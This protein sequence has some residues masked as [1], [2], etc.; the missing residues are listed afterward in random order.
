[1]K[2]R[3]SLLK[4]FFLII[5]AIALLGSVRAGYCQSGRQTPFDRND[6][7]GD[8]LLSQDEFK[9][10]KPAFERID[11][12]NDGYISKSELGEFRNEKQGHGGNLKNGKEPKQSI[13]APDAST[14][15]EKFRYIDTHQHLAGWAG[16]RGSMSDGYEQAAQVALSTMN[17]LGIAKMILMP[18]PQTVNQE[19]HHDIDDYLDIIKK[20][21]QRFAMLAGGGTLNVM[22][23][24]SVS[25]GEVSNKLRKKFEN[26]A[27]ELLAKGALGFGEMTAEHLSMNRTHPYIAVPPDHPLFLLLADIA[28]RHDVP[29]DLHME[30]I[31]EDMPLPGR[32]RQMPNNPDRLR[33]NIAAFERLLTHNPKAKIIWVH[34]GWDNTGQRTT[35]LSDRLLR[36]YPNLYMSIRV[37]PKPIP[38]RPTDAADRIKQEWLT[39]ITKHQDRFIIG[40]D[41]FFLPQTRG[42]GHPSGGSTE[43]TVQLLSLLPEDISRKVGFENAEKIYHLK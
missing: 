1:M 43:K 40:S 29:V 22:I 35:D 42:K 16:N 26:T 33:A 3:S 20:H 5:C 25:D 38:S 15:I 34:A 39:L 10:P 41:E 12:N 8:G 30:A 28:A 32:L 21:P 19:N 2:K 4:R 14:P 36:S 18:T 9:G 27:E 31:P 11:K 7:N 6:R 17:R 24:R 13:K 37:G 23:Q